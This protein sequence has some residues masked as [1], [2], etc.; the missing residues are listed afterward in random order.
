VVKLSYS[1]STLSNIDVE[2]SKSKLEQLMKNAEFY[3]NENLNLTSLAEATDLTSHQL[4]E[5]I[6]TQFGM[7][8]SQYL[9][10]VRITKA[11][12]LLRDKP[13]WSILAI[14]MEVGFKSQSNFYAAFKDLTNQSPG[15]YRK[16]FQN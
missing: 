3:Q 14:S 5:L 13:T 8:F 2:K 11:K 4:S 12:A 15:N 6:N 9:R 7:S 16:Q 1:T 10:E